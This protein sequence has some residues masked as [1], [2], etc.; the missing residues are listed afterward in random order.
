MPFKT[1][2]P[3]TKHTKAATPAQIDRTRDRYVEMIALA[4]K[5]ESHPNA[6]IDKAHRLLTRHWGKSDW[7]SRADIL[8]TV[9]WLL[10][11]GT[12]HPGS[13]KGGSAAR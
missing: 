9:D 11:V 12:I 5:L 13:A 10:K 1:S 7:A 6:M 3:Q 2:R 4:R 8:K